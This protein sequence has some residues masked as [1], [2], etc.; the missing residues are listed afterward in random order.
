MANVDDEFRQTSTSYYA[1]RYVTEDVK[2]EWDG[3]KPAKTFIYLKKNTANNTCVVQSIDGHYSQNNATSTRTE[4]YGTTIVPV[5]GNSTF[6][7]NERAPYSNSGAES[8]YVGKYS[9]NGNATY[10]NFEYTIY[11]A[12]VSAYDIYHVTIYG[13]PNASEIGNDARLE[14]TSEANRGIAKVYNGGYFFFPKGTTVTAADFTADE[15]E[16]RAATIVIRG[17]EITVTYDRI[18]T[19]ISTEGAWYKIKCISTSGNPSTKPWIIA[20][21]NEFRQSATN[22][23]ALRYISQEDKNTVDATKPAK[24]LIYLK[25][26][27]ADNTCVMQGTGGHYSTESAI[28]SRTEAY[29]TTITPATS[30]NSFII[31]KRNFYTNNGPE[32]PYV[33]K[34]ST[35]SDFSYTIYEAD[36]SAYDI[37]HVTI[38][39]VA[40]ASEIGNDARLQCTSEANEGIERVYNNG[41]FFFRKGTVVTASDFVADKVQYKNSEVSVNGNEITV[42]YVEA[43]V[44]E[45]DLKEA[46]AVLDV[47]GVGYPVISGDSY[48]TLQNAI[49]AEGQTQRALANAINTYKGATDIQYPEDGKTYTFTN[50]H[51]AGNKYMTC[52]ENGNLTMAAHTQRSQAKDLPVSAKFTCHVLDEAE[53]KYIF[54]T[55]NGNFLRWRGTYENDAVGNSYD[56]HSYLKIA[57]M[58]TSNYTGNASSNADLFGFVKI[59]GYRALNSNTNFSNFVV[60]ATGGFDRANDVSFYTNTYSTAFI[61]EEVPYANEAKLKVPAEPK[62]DGAV[63]AYASIYLPFATVIPENV[64]AYTAQVVNAAEG[65]GKELQ[66]NAVTGGYLP[67]NTAA[68]LTSETAGTHTFVPTEQTVS[69]ISENALTGRTL[70][71]GDTPDEGLCYYI[72]NGAAGHE[73]GFFRY[74]GTTLPKYKALL[75]LGGESPVNGLA[76]TLGTGTTGI[77]AAAT[78]A[79]PEKAYDLSGRRVTK[80]AKGLYIVNGKKI[81]VK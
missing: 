54:V 27:S 79:G 3:T 2:S 46:Q 48:N 53:H 56:E 4:A 62:G 32:S 20:A 37:Y 43:P 66:L 14:C 23:Y 24:A 5:T 60:N 22:F 19:E 10:S 74:T 8:P 12:D 64:T 65:D 29:G 75:E 50:I 11:S 13:A 51:H 58:Q 38:T 69:E 30:G 35:G 52:D 17:T 16:G 6:T 25:K 41:C 63:L 76:L 57:N 9:S 39:G 81:L 55:D 7:I 72:L 26:N 68:V 18:A 34:T 67:A 73:I 80:P 70:T 44:T 33:G 31:S 45:E 61:I 77:E 15:L 71:T 1:L 49:N 47:R 42:T 28:S 21:E 36:L 59:G 78:A 40:N